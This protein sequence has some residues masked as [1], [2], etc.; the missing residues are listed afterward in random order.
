MLRFRASRCRHDRPSGSLR[1]VRRPAYQRRDHVVALGGTGVARRGHHLLPLEA[2]ARS[3]H[4]DIALRHSERWSVLTETATAY[5]DRHFLSAGNDGDRP[6]DHRTQALAA[7]GPLAAGPLNRGP[8]A[9][10][11]HLGWPVQNRRRCQDCRHRG[12]RRAGLPDRGHK[13]HPIEVAA[14]ARQRRA[15]STLKPRHRRARQ[16]SHIAA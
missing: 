4:R 3:I 10:L 12:V 7:C 11:L 2:Q 13:F 15:A 16:P 8:S 9:D 5:R 1:W 14:P 6:L